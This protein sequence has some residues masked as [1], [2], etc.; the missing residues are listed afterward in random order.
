MSQPNPDTARRSSV[1]DHPLGFW[2]FFWGEFAERCC[3]YGMRAILLLYMTQILKFGDGE[4]SR[5]MSYYIA[6]CYVLPLVG[7]YVAD[8]FLGKYRTIVYFALP[9]I[10]GQVLLGIESLHNEKCLML[11][12]GL[13]AMGSGVIKPNISTLMGMTYDQFRPGKTKLRSDAFALF[14]GSINIG[15]ALS[16][17]CVPWI[18]NYYGGDSRAYAIAFLFPAALMVLAFVVFMLGKPFYAKEV[19]ERKKSTPEER[20]ERMVVLR[21]LFGLFFVVMIFWSI[22]DQ[23]TSTWTLFA[24][25]FLHLNL[26]GIPLSADQLQSAN[27]ILIILLLPPITMFWHLL[28]HWGFDLKPTG[29]MLIGFTLTTVTM[30]ITAWAAFRGADTIVAGAPEALAQAKK[31][32]AAS[33]LPENAVASKAAESLLEAERWAS[34]MERMPDVKSHD[35]E[36]PVKVMDAALESV[37]EAGPEVVAVMAS[38]DATQTVIHTAEIAFDTASRGRTGDTRRTILFLETVTQCTQ[39]RVNVITSA[40]KM[41]TKAAKEEK[42]KR[43]DET[44]GSNVNLADCSKVANSVEAAASALE[45]AT[46]AMKAGNE[47]AARINAAVAA[48]HAN[49]AAVHLARAVA[50]YRGVE[51]PA[52]VADAQKAVADARV[53]VF[54]QVVP[55]ILITISEICI[56]VVGLELAFAAAPAAMKSFVT[57]CWLLVVSLGNI[58]NAQITPLYNKTFDG[59]SLTP[60]WYFLIFAVV[61]VPVTIA[62][63]LV[64]RRFNRPPA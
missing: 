31:T 63:A 48:A 40:V 62:F 7:G 56:S 58:F 41:A 23:S 45:K 53:S 32:V 26:L 37:K 54:W 16:S 29:K 11:S 52:I 21:R 12:L 47:K 42:T 14:Y 55:Y 17:F 6:A 33:T 5:V 4:A 50:S 9:Y 35:G 10:F 39:C 18:R 43:A 22:F 20:H 51:P 30:G 34:A 44:V 2:F 3:Y 24:R 38:R 13:L 8:H 1:F 28:S 25:D 27:P 59:V 57:A 19:I 36:K 61:M 49:D 60:D 15:A 46:D 64:A